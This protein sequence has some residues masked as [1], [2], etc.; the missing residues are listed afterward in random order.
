[1][2]VIGIDLGGTKLATVLFDDKGTMIKKR[3]AP[4]DKRKGSEVGRLITSELK[5]ML[6]ENDDIV[7]VG[8]SVPGIYH[9][10]TGKVW[11]PNIP[12]WDDYPL[13]EEIDSTLKDDKSLFIDSDRSCYILGEIWKGNAV[14][15]KNAIFIAVGTGIGAGIMVNGEILR[16]IG[17]SAGAVGWMALDRPFQEPYS[18]YGCFESHASGEGIVRTA[19]KYLSEKADYN[20]VLEKSYSEDSLTTRDI[21]SAY[22]EKDTIA[23]RVIDEAIEFWGMALANLISIFNPEKI[24]FGGGVF[25]AAG[26]FIDDIREEAKRWAQPIGFEQVSVE[27]A[28]LGNEA[29][30]YGAGYLALLEYNQTSEV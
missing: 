19:K 9:Q 24:I 15:C 8:I 6:S 16:G 25:D 4:L 22:Y 11:A 7:S 27:L 13:R 1:M 26:D 2:K 12:E 17:N 14:G 10:D 21:F 30:I 28:A 3:F 5:K 29:G 18:K 23:I 20:G